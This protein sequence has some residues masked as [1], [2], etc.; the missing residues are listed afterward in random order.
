MKTFKLLLLSIPLLFI[1]SCDLLQPELEGGCTDSKALNQDFTADFDDGS[2][3][4]STVVFYGRYVYYGPFL[5]SIA[6]VDVTIDGNYKGSLSAVYPNGPSNCDA[7]GTVKHEFE[8]GSSVN[9][10]AVITLSNGTFY[11]A[12]GTVSPSSSQSCIRINATP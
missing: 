2:C 6:K 8:D 9:W 1:L 10:N 3:E 4:Y 11:T 5:F 7:P 12:G